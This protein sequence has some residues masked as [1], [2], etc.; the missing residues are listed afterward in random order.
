MTA[1]VQPVPAPQSAVRIQR[2]IAAIRAQGGS[3]DDV[4]AYLTQHE[5]LKPS[6]SV[7]PTSGLSEA[8]VTGMKGFMGGFGDEIGGA[9]DA[10]IDALSDMLHGRPTHFSDDYATSR[11]A[12]RATDSQF[13]AKSPILHA[14]AEMLGAV[15]PTMLTGGATEAAIGSRLAPSL[16]RKVLSSAITGGV[17]SGVFGAGNAT[18]DAASRLSGAVKALPLGVAV[19]AAAPVIGAGLGK[20]P[21]TIRSLVRSS[22]GL[23]TKAEAI[24]QIGEVVGQSGKTVDQIASDASAHQA[25]GAPVMFADELGDNG[26]K[27]VRWAVNQPSEGAANLTENLGQRQIGQ[28]ERILT[29]LRQSFGSDIANLPE[30]RDALLAA[31]RA[32]A[33]PLYAKAYA[34]PAYSSPTLDAAMQYPPFRRAIEQGQNLAHA[35]E[36]AEAIRNNT[37]P[38]STP[39]PVGAPTPARVTANAQLADAL[40]ENP[41]MNQDAIARLAK[42][43]GA[44]PA[45]LSGSQTPQSGVQVPIK[46]L[47][48]AKRYLDKGIR[49]GFDANSGFDHT[50]AHATNNVL[51]GVLDEVDQQRPN[52]LAARQQYH[53]DSRMEEMADLGEKAHNMTPDELQDALRGASPA[54]MDVAR[55]TFLGAYKNKAGSIR[56]Q[57]DLSA[58]FLSDPNMR[59]RFAIM[60]PNQSA[61]DATQ[62][63]ADRE[64]LMASTYRAATGNSTTAQQQMVDRAMNGGVSPADIA[65]LPISPHRT[66]A[67]LAGRYGEQLRNQS[68]IKLSNQLSG[69]LQ[70]KPGTSEYDDLISAL[71]SGNQTVAPGVTTR[72][73]LLKRAIVQAFALPSGDR[74]Q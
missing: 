54:E 6:P 41:G 60:A 2:N 3:D 65:V 21:A 56:D 12:L 55:K 30:T 40:K 43:L 16:G 17:T 64:G 47:D 52:W 15:L 19:G 70:T 68:N 69:L 46:V 11:D 13:A 28:Y 14:G 63:L 18:G 32:N 42:L 24:R 66:I 5:G 53:S 31:K 61:T 23:G 22:T 4:E 50:T 51:G 1:P 8:L 33:A 27:I 37:A 20:A 25:A 62:A 72:N 26:R 71:R 7:A 9:T 44:D 35:D 49:R 45:S 39:V 58:R 67:R 73:D 29:G 59:A 10:G 38:P 48:Y 74:R 34:D 57:N 36:L